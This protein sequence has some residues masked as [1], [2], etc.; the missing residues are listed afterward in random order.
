MKQQLKEFISTIEEDPDCSGLPASGE[1][2]CDYEEGF[3]AGILNTYTGE[4]FD[5]KEIDCRAS[6]GRVCGFHAKSNV[7]E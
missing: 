5:V 3:I 7:L 1:T 2:V 6:G 4:T